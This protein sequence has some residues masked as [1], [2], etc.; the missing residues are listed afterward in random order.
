[1]RTLRHWPAERR[2]F[3]N[4]GY[5]GRSRGYFTNRNI[6]EALY[7]A[8]RTRAFTEPPPHRVTEFGQEAWL[9]QLDLLV[10]KAEYVFHGF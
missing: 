4:M 9:H 8:V 10:A 1:M 7:R 6:G 3:E 5:M 2:I